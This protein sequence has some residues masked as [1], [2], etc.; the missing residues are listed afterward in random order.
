VVVSCLNELNDFYREMI[1]LCEHC[2]V[3]A[4]LLKN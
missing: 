1:N 4:C 3:V 2:G